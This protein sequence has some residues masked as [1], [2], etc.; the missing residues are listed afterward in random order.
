MTL[1]GAFFPARRRNR[2][3]RGVAPGIAGAPELYRSVATDVL[4][5]P[6][7]RHGEPA[8]GETPAPCEPQR[9]HRSQRTASL[10]RLAD[11]TP[12]KPSSERDGSARQLTAQTPD[13]F[14]RVPNK[15]RIDQS[16]FEPRGPVRAL[17]N[18]VILR[19][20]RLLPSHSV[21]CAAG[22]VVVL[23]VQI[24]RVA[25]LH[26]PHEARQAA[27][28]RRS[29]QPPTFIFPIPISQNLHA[30]PQRAN[31]QQPAGDCTVLGVQVN[32][33]FLI[34]LLGNQVN[35]VRNDM[36]SRSRH[37]TEYIGASRRKFR[38]VQPGRY[39]REMKGNNS[40][41][42]N[43]STTAQFSA[44]QLRPDAKLRQQE[45][46]PP[47]KLTPSERVPGTERS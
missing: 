4:R 37:N 15:L 11:R 32:R 18:S 1:A 9:K 6:D 28:I 43:P 44:G 17:Q 42:A 33:M 24:A 25:A 39:R 31:L 40:R 12:D 3:H 35:T 5:R 41:K 47:V 10:Q 2:E 38:V 27:R 22:S 8:C 14:P 29:Q 16:S 30:I 46:A 23:L 19:V 21:Q 13:M 26:I 45:P 20:A 7:I 36:T 34:P